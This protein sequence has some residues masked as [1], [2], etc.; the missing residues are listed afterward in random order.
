LRTRRVEF[1]VSLEL[2]AGVSPSEDPEKVLKAMRNVIGVG[3]A[4]VVRNA[5]SI[6]I[7]SKSRKSLERMRDQLR[8]RRVRGAA[9]RLILTRSEGGS[10]TIML[11][12]QA[13]FEGV[14]ALCDNEVESPLGPIYLRLESDDIEGLTEWLTAY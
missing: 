14:I 12:R 7:I 5:D 11:N 9:R 6:V 8:D 2:R 1:S 3:E 13:A 10:A 4:Q